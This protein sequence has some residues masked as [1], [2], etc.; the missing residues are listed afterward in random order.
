[1]EENNSFQQPV[2]AGAPPISEINAQFVPPS[3]MPT[4]TQIPP[5]VLE[6]MKAKAREEAV[7][8]TMEQ[9][10]QM[11]VPTLPVP[12]TQPNVVYVRRNLTVAELLLTLLLACGIVTGVQ[13][14]WKTISGIMPQI[15]IKVK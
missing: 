8:I 1:M 9:R 12:G 13:L 2:T 5:G 6:L 14:G 3:N 15:E 7:R 11:P 4:P 10:G